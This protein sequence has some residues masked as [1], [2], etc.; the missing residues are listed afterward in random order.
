MP[1]KLKRG[2]LVDPL[3]SG[4]RAAGAPLAWGKVH[5]Y[6]P[7]TATPAPLFRTIDKSLPWDGPWGNE[8]ALDGQGRATA[9]GDGLYKLVI[10]DLEGQEVDTW[11]PLFFGHA[12]VNAR[13][14]GAVGAGDASIDKDTAALQEAIDYCVVTGA[15]LFIPAGMYKLTEPLSVARLVKTEAEGPKGFGECSVE[16]M[17]EKGASGIHGN[18]TVLLATF[19]DRPALWIQAA[20]GVSLVRLAFEGLN[21][22]ALG[23]ELHELLDDRTFVAEGCRDGDRREPPG[24]DNAIC[25]PYA[26]VAIDPFPGTGE[27]P[28]DGGYPGLDNHYYRQSPPSRGVSIEQCSFQRFV[29]GV[30]VAPAGA[31]R[32]P[33]DVR[34]ADTSFEQ[35]KV[36]I[37]VGLGKAREIS[38]RNVRSFGNQFFVSTRSYGDGEPGADVPRVG[39]ATVS[40]TKYLFHLD[41]GSGSA[42]IEGIACTSTLGLGFVTA[43]GDPGGFPVTFVGCNFDFAE[44]QPA[45]DTHLWA[46]ANVRFVGCTFASYSHALPVRFFNQGH[47]SFASCSFLN[48]TSDCD[49]ES[50]PSQIGFIGVEDLARVTFEECDAGDRSLPEQLVYLERIYKTAKLE[51]LNRS[52]VPPGSTI[53]AGD[54]SDALLRVSAEVKEIRMDG[55]TVMLDAERPGEADFFAPDPSTLK[56]GDL[57]FA[58]GPGWIPESYSEPRLSKGVCGVIASIKGSMVRM[59][60]VVRGLHDG[61]YDLSVR[62]L[63]RFHL[64][65]SGMTGTGSDVIVNVTHAE[66]WKQF[67][68]ISGGGIPIGAYIV[69]P[70]L[71]G[72]TRLRISKP[73]TSTSARPVRLYD[74]D[75]ERFG[76]LIDARDRGE[77]E[78][79]PSTKRPARAAAE[80]LPAA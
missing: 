58:A 24:Y 18:D 51:S 74:A 69:D 66:T 38:V 47:L 13:D 78:V 79:P 23:G 14:F 75:I 20:R 45:V 11:E 37:A 32:A 26:G 29:V 9:Y 62:Y 67:D 25:S 7:G 44:P 15:K 21:N 1:I 30:V 49:S 48:I 39:G 57:V 77:F 36:S 70:V 71:P 42:V 64:S 19:R 5:A 35:H 43:S 56:P 28:A 31:E 60:S 8:V 10:C 2:V 12:V 63:P 80:G 52:I 4:V 72:A 55:V 46:T 73:A 16:I 65:S 33:S 40:G 34:I 54:V 50:E 41:A 68:R 22:Y 6:R 17:G 53:V 61:A 27:L 59:K 76:D 3:V